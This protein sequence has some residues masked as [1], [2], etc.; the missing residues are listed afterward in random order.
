MLYKIANHFVKKAWETCHKSSNASSSFVRLI[1]GL[2]SFL[3]FQDF[4]GRDGWQ[5]FTLSC[6]ILFSLLGG[7][8]TAFHTYLWL[9]HQ[10]FL[11]PVCLRNGYIYWWSS[12]RMATFGFFWV[13]K[14]IKRI[15]YRDF[16]AFRYPIVLTLQFCLLFSHKLKKHTANPKVNCKICGNK[17]YPWAMQSHMAAHEEAKF[18]CEV[19]GKRVKKK[20]ELTNHMRIHTGENPYRYDPN[21]IL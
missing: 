5:H 2:I 16:S 4:V 8:L 20:S 12:F 14:S 10:F 19:C 1:G 15:L 11:L 3:R 21:P 6:E 18:A 9:F 7:I 17:Y 13:Q